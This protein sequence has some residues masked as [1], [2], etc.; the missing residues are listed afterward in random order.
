MALWNE[1]TILSFTTAELSDRQIIIILCLGPGEKSHDTVCHRPHPTQPLCSSLKIEYIG[2]AG[3]EGQAAVKIMVTEA[4]CASA[5]FSCSE[6]KKTEYGS[7]LDG[8][9]REIW[10]ALLQK[11]LEVT[12]FFQL[13]CE[14]DT[15][16]ENVAWVEILHILCNIP[17][18]VQ[19]TF[20][21]PCTPLWLHAPYPLPRR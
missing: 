19:V 20:E 3:K 2:T 17:P 11:E 1:T 14:S 16:W 6:K 8:V 7:F 9:D 5:L 21:I 15:I 12:H 10:T 18:F 4:L 13:F